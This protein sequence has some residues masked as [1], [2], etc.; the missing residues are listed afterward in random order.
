MA[1]PA[2]AAAVAAAAVRRRRLLLLP[3]VVMGRGCRPRRGAWT[4]P[5]RACAG[6]SLW[7]FGSGPLLLGMLGGLSCR[8]GR[9]HQTLRSTVS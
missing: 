9:C 2:A 4:L 3:V 5:R 1:V 7:P 8:G 6:S